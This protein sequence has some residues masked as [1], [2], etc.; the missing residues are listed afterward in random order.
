M[1]RANDAIQLQDEFSPTNYS[2]FVSFKRIGLHQ[3]LQLKLFYRGQPLALLKQNYLEQ[4]GV[5]S[6]PNEKVTSLK[7]K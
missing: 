2:F 4:D 7:N 6:Q 3:L 5:G 1:G